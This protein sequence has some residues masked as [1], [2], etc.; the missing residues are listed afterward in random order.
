MSR[1]KDFFFFFCGI[2]TKEE[3]TREGHNHENDLRSLKTSYTEKFKEFTHLSHQ[4]EI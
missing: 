1:I 2:F 4:R 3:V